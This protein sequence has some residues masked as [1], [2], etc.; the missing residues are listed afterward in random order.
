VRNERSGKGRSKWSGDAELPPGEYQLR[1]D[2]RP[3]WR[4]DVHVLPEPQFKR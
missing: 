2:G 1:V 4:V 3:E